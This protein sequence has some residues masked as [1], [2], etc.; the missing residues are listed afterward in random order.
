MR[1]TIIDIVETRADCWIQNMILSRF[2]ILKG[3]LIRH[4]YGG[5]L[6]YNGTRRSFWEKFDF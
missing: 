3:L 6:S 5:S 2:H 4:D 1:P